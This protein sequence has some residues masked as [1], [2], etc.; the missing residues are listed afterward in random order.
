MT[1]GSVNWCQGMLTDI[2]RVGLMLRQVPTRRSS[3]RK[4]GIPR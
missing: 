2:E 3:D 4:T 1:W